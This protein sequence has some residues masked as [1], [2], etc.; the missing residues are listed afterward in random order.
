MS[1]NEVLGLIIG[2]IL[3]VA[4]SG[5]LAYALFRPEKF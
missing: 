1:G 5:Y 2:G 3:V 4:L